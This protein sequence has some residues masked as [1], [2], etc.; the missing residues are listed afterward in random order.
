MSTGGL[1]ERLSAK[2]QQREVFGGDRT[3]VYSIAWCIGA[4][5]VEQWLRNHLPMQETPD[6]W[7]QSLSGEDPLE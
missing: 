7:V 1:R 3:V 2:G 5:Q 4:Y 6:T